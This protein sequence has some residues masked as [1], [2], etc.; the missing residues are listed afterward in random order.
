M[1]FR[2]RLA[3]A[4]LHA[5]AK[6]LHYN[7]LLQNELENALWRV[8]AYDYQARGISALNGGAVIPAQASPL[9]TFASAVSALT[10]LTIAAFKKLF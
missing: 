10:P 2:S 9:S 1:L 5:E 6:R 7:D 4:Q 3:A 8:K